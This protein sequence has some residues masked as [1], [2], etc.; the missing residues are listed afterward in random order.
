MACLLIAFVLSIPLVVSARNPLEAVVGG[1]WF[2]EGFGGERNDRCKGA[3]SWDASSASSQLS[4]SCGDDDILTRQLSVRA[5]SDNLMEL[6]IAAAPSDTFDRA[7]LAEAVAH[8]HAKD[9]VEGPTTSVLSSRSCNTTEKKPC[10]LTLVRVAPS[11]HLQREVLHFSLSY[12]GLV[13]ESLTFFRL[14]GL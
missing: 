14:E 3:L 2:V 1:N 5:L 12:A 8:F 13:E 6:R 4:T 7:L 10:S 11:N 9:V